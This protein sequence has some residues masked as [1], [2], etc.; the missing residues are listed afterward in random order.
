MA[1]LNRIGDLLDKVAP[2]SGQAVLLCVLVALL[3][4]CAGCATAP[5][6]PVMLNS[7][8]L[9]LLRDSCHGGSTVDVGRVEISS[10]NYPCELLRTY[11][12]IEATRGRGFWLGDFPRFMLK[13]RLVTKG[14]FSGFA[15]LVGLG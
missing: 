7:E 14:I 1:F 13:M 3:F 5:S 9:S 15:G 4:A 8:Q 12:A 10:S 11:A 6:A 2:Y